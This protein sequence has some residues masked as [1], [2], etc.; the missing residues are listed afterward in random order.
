MMFIKRFGLL[1]VL[2]LILGGILPATAQEV[3]EADDQLGVVADTAPTTPEAA[4]PVG[5]IEAADDSVGEPVADEEALDAADYEG[6]RFSLGSPAE[7]AGA[8]DES[9]AV[10][11]EELISA[12]DIVRVM[13][14]EDPNVAYEGAV[15]VGGT[16]PIPYYGE[17][18][19]AGMTQSAAAK[20]LEAE[21]SQGLYQSATVSVTLISRGPGT[22][23]VYGAVQNPG[24]ISVPKYG[25]LT[26]LRVLLLCGGLTGWAAPED[27]FIMRQ[28]RR[29]DTVERINVNLSEVFATALPFSE[30]D[31]PLLDG[32]IV[33][34]PGLNGELYQFMSQDDREVILV[35]EV[36]RPG[37]VSFRPGELRT[38]MRAIFKAGGFSQFAKKDAIRIIRYNRDNTRSELVVDAEEIMEKGYLHKDIE[39]Q[40]GDMLIVPQKRVNF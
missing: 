26:I 29:T 16:V 32:D 31:V 25:N 11:A 4:V 17:F 40:P 28:N 5:D 21:L 14:L 7:T 36:G 39:L 12:G 1:A 10:G 19:I 27:T 38:V 35:G 9:G 6:S 30:T 8:T 13:V 24:G 37:I 33:C 22:V 15:S 20:K 2:A 3:Q 23:Y 18:Q 34:V